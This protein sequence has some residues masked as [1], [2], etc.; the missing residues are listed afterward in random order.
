[1]RLSS[2]D[3]FLL[4]ATDGFWQVVTRRASR[5]HRVEAALASART[6]DTA[7]EALAALLARWRLDDNVALA[8]VEL[9][10]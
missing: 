2:D 6:A 10:P 8:V 1:V 5:R 9:G 7:R 4:V 3:Q